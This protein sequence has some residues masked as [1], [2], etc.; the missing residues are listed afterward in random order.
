MAASCIDTIKFCVLCNQI[1][2]SELPMGTGVHPHQ[3]TLDANEY[4][5]EG[6]SAA[7]WHF[8]E[9]YSF[10]ISKDFPELKFE[11]V[12]ETKL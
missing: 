3:N 10:K 7:S 1:K 4:K 11:P 6:I 5:R 8:E 12:S 9:N 2:L